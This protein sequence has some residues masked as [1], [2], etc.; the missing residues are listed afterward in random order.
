MVPSLSDRLK[1]MRTLTHCIERLHAVGWLHKG[2]C[3]DNILFFHGAKADID[4]SEPYLSGFDYSR[5]A[6]ASSLSEVPASSSLLDG[7]YRH[8][9][10]Q[11]QYPIEGSSEREGFNRYHDIYSLGIVMLEMQSG[12]R[13]RR[14]RGA[15]MVLRALASMITRTLAN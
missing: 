10:V 13:S 4:L 5:S 15:R 9:N 14:S 3:S 11:G 12:A 8:P 2:L 7:I 1:L 6:A